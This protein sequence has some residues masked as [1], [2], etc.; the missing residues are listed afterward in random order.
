M[1]A[2]KTLFLIITFLSFS[3]IVEAQYSGPS[4]ISEFTTIEDVLKNAA[5]L[6]RRDE[7]VK[8]KGYIIQQL[9]KDTFIFQD[10]TGK[11]EVEI[12]GKYMPATPFDDKTEIVIIGEVDYNLL[13]GTEIEAKSV[14][15]AT[16]Y[17][18]LY[19]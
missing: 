10:A 5:R 8:V 11:I 15:I 14:Y 3:E 16:E 19:Q 17:A 7:L 9:N 6:D 1:K 12:E 18:R 4:S 13:N 2:I